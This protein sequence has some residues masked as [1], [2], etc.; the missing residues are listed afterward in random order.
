M[1]VSKATYLDS[2]ALVK[3]ALVE[4]ESSALRSFLR[5]RRVRVSSAVARTE[6]IRAVRSGGIADAEQLRRAR[7][8]LATIDLVRVSD[9]ILDAASAMQPPELRTLD[10]IHLATA[11]YLDGD[12]GTFVTYDDRLAAAAAARGLKVAQPR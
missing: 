1:S 5:S 10:A 11:E 2:S 7:Q 3:L 6:V 4:P 9:R 8:A 12:V